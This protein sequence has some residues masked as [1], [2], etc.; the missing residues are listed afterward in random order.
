MAGRKWILLCCPFLYESSAHEVPGTSK[1]CQ[2][3]CFALLSFLFESWAHRVGYKQNLL[4]IFFFFGY[5]YCSNSA[6]SLIFFWAAN[7][8]RASNFLWSPSTSS[9][10]LMLSSCNA[11]FPWIQCDCWN[12]LWAAFSSFWEF[13]T[14]RQFF[15]RSRPS[16]ETLYHKKVW[17][18]TVEEIF[19]PPPPSP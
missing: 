5:W 14:T 18:I 19:L 3:I 9:R 10:R 7:L 4:H 11:S 6:G 17:F 16:N 13:N 12:L 2:T 8:L 1:I 15:S